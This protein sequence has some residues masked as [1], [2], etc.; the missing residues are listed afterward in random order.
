M[1]KQVD[2]VYSNESGEQALALKILD[3]S[4]KDS[5]HVRKITGLDP[6][7]IDLF[8]GEFSRD[9]GLYQGR[10]VPSRNPVITFDIRPNYANGETV[11]GWREIL[12]KIFLD[13][14]VDADY[15]Q[16]ILREDDG[17]SRYLVGYAE[18][19][20]TEI[21]DI[22]TMCQVSL[23]CPDPYIR[24]L[25]ET[26]LTD[27]F[28]WLTVPFT[29]GGTA[30][31]GFEVSITITNN[32]PTLTLVNNGK[33]MVVTYP[34]LVGDVVYFNTNRGSRNITVTRAGVTTT[35]IAQ[36][37]P[38]SR[39]LELH[40]A[41]NSMGVYGATPAVRPAGIRSLTYTAAYWGI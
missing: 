3:L 28:G 22:E 27:P 6:P 13:P 25:Q 40:S 2:L 19:F 35:L 26:V 29:Y 41:A 24:D 14:R 8:I 16:I 31:T 38:S 17:R 20:E 33:T 34:F 37:S 30:E 23:I 39:W 5:L 12:Y 1:L 11:A 9:G 4:P 21:F 36:L 7:G 15:S 10:R 18:K 32:T